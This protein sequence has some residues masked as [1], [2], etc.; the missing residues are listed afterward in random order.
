M[1]SPHGILIVP[2]ILAT[3]VWAM[4]SQDVVEKT[5]EI[6]GE[7]L[8]QNSRVLE[9]PEAWLFEDFGEFSDEQY[10]EVCLAAVESY[11]TQL[12]T[13]QIRAVVQGLDKGLLGARDLFQLAL[14]LP[15]ISD[16]TRSL[17]ESAKSEKGYVLVARSRGMEGGK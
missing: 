16:Q 10:R 14:T 17:F 8:Y 6:D 12:S 11:M 5:I 2:A 1:T 7:T 3:W 4:P 13:A 9:D 15:E